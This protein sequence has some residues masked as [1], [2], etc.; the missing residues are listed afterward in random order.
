ML[1]LSTG[2]IFVCWW[3]L[4]VTYLCVG[5]IY[6]D[7]FVCYG[8]IYVFTGGIFVCWGYLTVTYLCVGGIYW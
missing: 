5:G 4:T 3:Y 8:Y 2:G 7:V 1:E 6:R